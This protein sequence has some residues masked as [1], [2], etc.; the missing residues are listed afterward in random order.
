MIEKNYGPEQPL[1]AYLV[2]CRLTLRAGFHPVAT[3]KTAADEALTVVMKRN[4]RRH[5]NAAHID[6]KMYLL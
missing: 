4:I 5:Q 1:L 2:R 3:F 6:S